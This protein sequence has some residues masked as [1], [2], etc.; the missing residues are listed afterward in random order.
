MFLIL[1]LLLITKYRRSNSY[2]TYI[3]N[4]VFRFSKLAVIFAAF[5]V[6]GRLCSWFVAIYAAVMLFG[7]EEPYYNDMSLVQPITLTYFQTLIDSAEHADPSLTYIVSVQ[8]PLVESS[9]WFDSEFAAASLIYGYARSSVM[10][11]SLNVNDHPTVCDKFQIVTPAENRFEHELPT[12]LMF[13]NGKLV[14]RLPEVGRKSLLNV[15]NMRR[16][17]DLDNRA[18]ID[19]LILKEKNG[20]GAENEKKKKK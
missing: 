13:H 15:D 14:A 19:P 18:R 12:V 9:R 1:L 10:F 11:C 16:A 6:D 17:F 5:V 4:Y 7:P 8:S 20:K 3:N 2:E